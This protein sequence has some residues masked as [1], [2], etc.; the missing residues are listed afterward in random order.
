MFE[1]LF[2]PLRVGPVQLKNR[3]QLLPHNTLYDVRT[4][5]GY[6][7]RRA[8][9]GV[10]LVEVSMA[11]A[12]RDL[13]EFPEGPLDAWPYKGYDERIVPYY[14][15][16]SEAVHRHGAKAFIELSAA[17][18]NRSAARSASSIPGGIKRVTPRAYDAEGIRS[19]V[20]DHVRAARHIASGGFD[21]IDLH[22]TH[23]M[24]LEEFYSSA[25]NRREDGYGGS[26]DN[27]VRLIS[28]IISG[29]RDET[30][31][32]LAVGM[33]IDA[34]DGFPGGNTLAD[35]VGVAIALRGKLDFLNVDTGFEHQR[36]HLAI[37]PMYEAPGYLLESAGTFKRALPEMVIGAAGRIVD[38]VMAE[39]ILEDGIADLVGMTR[40]LIADPDLPNKAR[41]GRLDQIRFCLGDNQKCIGSMLRNMPMRCTVNPLVGRE[42]EANLEPLPPAEVRK[43]VLVIG[44]GVA[45]LE[46]A[47]TTASRGHEVV[48]YEGSSVLGGQV[49]L[50][51][52]LPGRDDFGIVL[53]WY[54]SQL[55]QLGV[56]VEYRREIASTDAADFVLAEERPDFVVIATG[57]RPIT[58]GMQQFDYSA[59]KGHELA[60]TVDQVLSGAEVGKD[61]L[62][63]DESGFV[64]GLSLSE[65]LAK[66]GSKVELVTRDPAP[67][68]ETRWSLQLPYLY[69]RSL[70]AGVVFTPNT[71]VSEI[72]QDSV[73]LFN[74]YT[75]DASSRRGQ[76]T[77]ILNTGRI[78]NDGPYSLFRGKVGS[79]VTVGDCNLAR[80]EMGEV[81]AEAFELTRTI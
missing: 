49:N 54:E 35:E 18:G 73:S 51:R 38:P 67:G 40:A 76:I 79:L 58:D 77:V 65:M 81:I 47:R 1:K 37:A 33:R 45:G 34:G 63:L 41:E 53:R 74:V 80:R 23:G 4:L 15:Q 27:R 32:R 50:A 29:I 48:V 78:P 25:T 21:G 9:G 61:V 14:S 16:L 31:G 6:L 55:R 71:F 24:L 11:T 7:E 60:L 62:I 39:S 42:S 57:S 20:D 52:R 26:L 22:A 8:K 69:E 64:E 56:R 2:Q 59:I 75:G 30:G 10:G 13:G 3:L 17:G 70:R 72:R 28:E 68:L 66:R 44:A 46:A 12:I 36:M 19:L 43:K 5:T